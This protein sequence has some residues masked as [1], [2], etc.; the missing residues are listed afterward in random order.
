MLGEEDMSLDDS[1]KN[2]IQGEF[3]LG[4]SFLNE[5]IK[6]FTKDH[7]IK[8]LDGYFVLKVSNIEAKLDYN[9]CE[10]NEDTRS[11]TF[12]LLDL[13]PFYFK[14]FLNILR[15]KFPFLKFIKNTEKT[16]LLTCHLNRIPALKDNKIVNSRYLQ[17]LTIKYI[18]CTEGKVAVK[19][20]VTLNALKDL[21]SKFGF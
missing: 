3:S 8:L 18:K 17:Y 6:K 2:L 5:C 14:P 12:K 4:E 15:L 16:G 7:S 10:F 20:K 19:L 9:S 11:V 13:K 1:I 21:A